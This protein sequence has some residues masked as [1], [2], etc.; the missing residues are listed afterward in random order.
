MSS[1]SPQ[2]Q[3]STRRPSSSSQRSTASTEYAGRRAGR[4]NCAVVTG[5]TSTRPFHWPAI[6]VAKPCQETGSPMQPLYRVPVAAGSVFVAVSGSVH[7][8]LTPFGQD[9]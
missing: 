9:G 1:E 8:E 4:G 7:H 2:P 6:S 3:C 5:C